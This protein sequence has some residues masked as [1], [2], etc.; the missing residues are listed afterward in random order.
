MTLEILLL[1]LVTGG[2]VVGL[3]SFLIIPSRQKAEAPLD[4]HDVD[5]PQRAVADE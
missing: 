4:A 1:L 2:V 5:N 3:A